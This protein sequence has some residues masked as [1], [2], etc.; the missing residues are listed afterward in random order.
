LVLEARWQGRRIEAATRLEE[1]PAFPGLL[2]D[3]K[4]IW[5]K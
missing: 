3:L 4:P 2:I 1:V 5:A